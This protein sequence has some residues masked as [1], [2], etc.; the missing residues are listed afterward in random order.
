MVASLQANSSAGITWQVL[1][2]LRALR[3]ASLAALARQTRLPRTQVSMAIDR[4]QHHGLLAIDEKGIT[5]RR[6]RLAPRALLIPGAVLH[7]DRWSM[8][9][10]DL[11][12]QPVR[13][14]DVL[15]TGSMPSEVIEALDL[16]YARLVGAPGERPIA[17]TLG[18]ALPGL[19]DSVSGSVL[20]AIELD[21]VQT[22]IVALALKKLSL[23]HAH[24]I[25]SGQAGALAE[26][27]C[28]AGRGVNDLV[29]IAIDAGISAGM[30]SHGRLIEGAGGLAGQLGHMTIAPEGPHCPCGNEGCLQQL[31]SGSAIVA[32]A[33]QRLAGQAAGA[34][35]W[36]SGGRP[37]RLTSLA[38]LDAAR[39]NDRSAFN[40]VH[41]AGAHLGVAI[42]NLINLL[43]P[44]VIVLGGL[45]G[46][47]DDLLLSAIR[48]EV[49]R[50]ALAEP[51][52]AARIVRS[53]LGSLGS[54][55][56]AAAA[57]LQQ[58][59]S[60]WDKQE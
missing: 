18:L 31:A 58:M 42:A 11:D 45:V 36:R 55:I 14:L 9:L 33:Q 51:L 40:I 59:V 24:L 30:I 60:C 47:A 50:R 21:W 41:E 35:Y 52:A 29:Y 3:E 46:A 4:L 5:S 17:P 54:A 12:I 20:S 28:G 6:F 38:V 32:Q 15:L 43:N 23:S 27:W 1:G 34:L 48:R 13:S 49:E 26:A 56:G 16:G 25:S 22:P 44:Q 57:A 8:A 10:V 2:E 19:V 53:S 39:R 7:E 37:E